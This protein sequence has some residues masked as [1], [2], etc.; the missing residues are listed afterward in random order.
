[1]YSN[2]NRKAFSAV[3]LVTNWE[4]YFDDFV[5]KL[6]AGNESHFYSPSLVS[7]LRSIW[8][9][10]FNSMQPQKKDE[11]IGYYV[12]RNWKLRLGVFYFAK[13]FVGN[14]QS[15]SSLWSFDSVRMWWNCGVYLLVYQSQVRTERRRADVDGCTTT[16][17]REYGTVASM[18]LD[19][20]SGALSL[21]SV[22][23]VWST[24]VVPVAAAFD[25]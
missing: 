11:S 13:E 4:N 25:L 9:N 2:G 14:C 15:F 20:T 17:I 18:V 1:M 21:I 24:A 23:V 7:S 5:R 19:W 6:A 22:L 12:K 16:W 10:I 8:V 3:A